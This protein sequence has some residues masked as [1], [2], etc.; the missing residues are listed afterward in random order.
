[1]IIF[2]NKNYKLFNL[3]IEA[4][5]FSSIV[6]DVTLNGSLV[7]IINS[8]NIIVNCIG[9]LLKKANEKPSRTIFLNSYFPYKLA[10]LANVLNSKL[11]I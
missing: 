3:S 5:Q 1:M 2:H 11:I 7:G 4:P 9:V 6:C 8:F 10:E